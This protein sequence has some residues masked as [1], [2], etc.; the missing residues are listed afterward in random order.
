KGRTHQQ[1]LTTRWCDLTDCTVARVRPIRL[2]LWV[3]IA[4]EHTAMTQPTAQALTTL[5][6]CVRV[7]I[8]PYRQAALICTFRSKKRGRRKQQRESRKHLLCNCMVPGKTIFSV[9]VIL[10]TL[11]KNCTG[12]GSPLSFVG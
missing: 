11:I 2:D 5:C 9:D 10:I 4:L 1:D 7:N 8:S 3:K 12:I 6:A